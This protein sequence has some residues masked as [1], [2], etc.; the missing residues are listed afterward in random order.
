MFRILLEQNIISENVVLRAM[1]LVVLY[2]N[3]LIVS[4]DEYMKQVLKINFN[5]CNENSLYLLF[6]SYEKSRRMDL[7]EYIGFSLKLLW[8]FSRLL[9]CRIEIV[10]LASAE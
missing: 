8:I 1:N 9:V 3:Q 4:C 6:K 2:P 5:A 7:G 10:F